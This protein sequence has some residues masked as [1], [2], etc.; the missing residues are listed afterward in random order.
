VCQVTH[1]KQEG[2]TLNKTCI[3]VLFRAFLSSSWAP[4]SERQRKGLKIGGKK[5]RK[6]S[7]LFRLNFLYLK[8]K[9]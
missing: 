1:H 9:V 8:D 5:G 2:L 7:D 4:T 3:S 6:K